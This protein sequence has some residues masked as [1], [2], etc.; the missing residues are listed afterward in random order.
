MA[1]DSEK[2][3]LIYQRYIPQE[4]Y[5]KLDVAMAGFPRNKYSFISSIY[6]DGVIVFC[7]TTINEST[8]TDFPELS[9]LIEMT[10]NE[11]I[12][13]IDLYNGV[14]RLSGKTMMHYDIKIHK[15]N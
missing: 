15:W 7:G 5:Q 6:E 9:K 10:K 8:S 2:I 12:R 4:E 3:L 13:Y 1:L 11:G 14:L